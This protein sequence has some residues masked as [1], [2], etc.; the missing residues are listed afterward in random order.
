MMTALLALGL[1]WTAAHAAP[2]VAEPVR[3]VE[4]VVPLPPGLTIEQALASVDDIPQIFELYEPAIP[5]IPGVDVALTKHV[6]SPVS[7]AVL[8]LPVS[9]NAIGFK[10]DERARV[11]ASTEPL[12]CAADGAEGRRITLDFQASS[13]NIERRIDRIEITACPERSA[14]GEIVLR[15]TGRMYEGF[16]AQDPE[17]PALSEA[18]GRKA[19]Q[20]A[21]MKQV[22]PILTA[23][24]VHWSML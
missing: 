10:F 11:T 15:A 21:F 20:S 3:V 6:V 14:D 16:N 4:E 8:E 2:A 9:G 7:P 23:V 5:R 12:A 18:I 24:Q 13:Y 17:K 22:T 19:L 1:S